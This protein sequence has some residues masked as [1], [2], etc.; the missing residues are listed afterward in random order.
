MAVSTNTQGVSAFGIDTANMFEFWDW[1]GGR[2]SLWSAIGLPIVL[3]V[4]MDNF[5]ALLSGAFEMDLHF[6]QAPLESNMPVILALLGIWY[7]NYFGAESQV[8]LPYDHYLRSLPMYLQQADM[9]SNGK[10][11]DRDGNPVTQSTGPII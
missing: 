1:V 5:I 11:V 8:I 6:R 3:S 4:G 2:Y 9:E 7:N 10:S